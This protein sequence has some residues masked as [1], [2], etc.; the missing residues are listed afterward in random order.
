MHPAIIHER[1]EQRLI[2][3]RHLNG[4]WC[5]LWQGAQI[6]GYGV[7]QIQGRRHH[8]HRVRW[9][10]AHGP[11]PPEHHV[12]QVCG[13]GLCCELSHLWAGTRE[14]WEAE[15]VRRISEG[16]ERRHVQG[17]ARHMEGLTIHNPALVLTDRPLVPITPTIRHP[18]YGRVLSMRKEPLRFTWGEAKQRVGLLRGM[19]IKGEAVQ[20]EWTEKGKRGKPDKVVLTWYVRVI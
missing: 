10:A 6:K 1:I 4:S 11:L 2:P 9:E 5:L 16:Q 14:G 19:G 3:E 18:V 15:Q 12:F 17:T 20:G 7:V 8:V 13:R